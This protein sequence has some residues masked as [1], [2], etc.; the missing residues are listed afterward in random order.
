[1]NSKH[2]M[3]LACAAAICGSVPAGTTETPPAVQA[4]CKLR[5]IMIA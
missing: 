2:M 4:S 1:M 3:P 5:L